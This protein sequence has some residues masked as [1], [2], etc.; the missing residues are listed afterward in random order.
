[1]YL[2]RKKKPKTYHLWTG[3]DTECKMYS[4]GGMKK[5]KYIVVE[6]HA[7]FSLCTMCRNVSVKKGEA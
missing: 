7:G 5:S 6:S 4:T 1:M 2:I 3:V